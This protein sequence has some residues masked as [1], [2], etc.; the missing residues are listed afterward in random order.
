MQS[1]RLGTLGSLSA[2][3]MLATLTA[4]CQTTSSSVKTDT[5]RVAC[6]S[7]EPI[8]WSG[9]DTRETVAKVKEHNAAWKA[10]CRATKP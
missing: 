10:L 9:K 5:V 8:Y 4:S 7:F 1:P 2:I 3:S 6:Q